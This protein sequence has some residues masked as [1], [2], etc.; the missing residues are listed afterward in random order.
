MGNAYSEI[1]LQASKHKKVQ[2]IMHYVRYQ[3]LL[4]KHPILKP[5][6]YASVW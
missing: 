1:A 5:K 4:R 2:T 3:L 6:I